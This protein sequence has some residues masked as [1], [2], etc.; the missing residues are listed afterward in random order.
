[1]PIIQI[2]K[3]TKAQIVHSIERVV[4]VFV[5]TVTGYLKTTSDPFSKAALSAAGFAGVAAVYQAVISL[6]TSL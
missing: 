4:L 6:T 5:V 3:P 1:M 2:S